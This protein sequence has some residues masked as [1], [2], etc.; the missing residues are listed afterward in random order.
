MYAKLGYTNE[1]PL[2][3]KKAQFHFVSLPTSTSPGFKTRLDPFDLYPPMRYKAR[4]PQLL[5]I[6]GALRFSP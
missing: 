4:L 1:C 6:V 3:K 5:L 2:L